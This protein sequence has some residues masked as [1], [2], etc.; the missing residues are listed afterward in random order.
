[1]KNTVKKSPYATF[2]AEPVKAPFPDT[3]SPKAN[4]IKGSDLRVKGEKKNG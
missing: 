1:M 3:H 2:S 4:S